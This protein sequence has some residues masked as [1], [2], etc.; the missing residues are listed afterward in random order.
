[1]T[2]ST[3]IVKKA[4]IATL[5]LSV[6]DSGGTPAY[7]TALGDKAYASEEI[8]RAILSATTTIMQA[9][10]ETPGH[11]L[12]SLFT[13]ATALTNAAQLPRHYGPIG[14]PRITPFSGAGYT[15]AGTMKSPEQVLSY[16]LN[17]DNLYSDIDHDQPDGDVSSKLAGYYAIDG[18][19]FYFTGYSCV[20][21]LADFTESS[22]T[23]LPDT[24]Y[25]LAID[26]AIAKLVKDG[27]VSDIFDKYMQ[28][29]AT[30]IAWIRQAGMPD[31]N[32]GN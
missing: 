21:D 17:P 14:Q 24:K 1:M 5:N 22:Y 20:S 31:K 26:L 4:V 28:M 8:D 3:D 6:R 13:T 27:N 25:P 11:P 9:I 23:L 15:L 32:G 29:G 19:T 30:E 2:F 16:R 10:C 12:R 18:T 7:T